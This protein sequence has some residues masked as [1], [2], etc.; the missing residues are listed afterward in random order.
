MR[1]SATRGAAGAFGSIGSDVDPHHAKDISFGG[2]VLDPHPRF[3]ELLAT[4]PVHPGS[5]S[6]QFATTS[7]DAML[8]PEDQQYTAY[9]FETVEA[10]FRDPNTFSSA[11]MA[12]LFEDVIGRTILEM[13]PPEHQRYRTLIQPGFTKAEMDRWEAEFVRDVVNGHIDRFVDDGR[14]DL[15]TDF[16]LHYPIHVTAVAIGLPTDDLSHFYREAVT[17]TNPFISET[18]RKRASAVLGDVLQRLIDERRRTR[19]DDLVST[20]V[21][22]SFRD[23]S[24]A[25]AQELTDEAIVAFARQL[26]PA[27]AQTTSDMITTLLFA[28]LTHPEQLAAVTDQPSLIPQAVEEGLRWESSITT[29]GRFT[30]RDVV[31]EDVPVPAASLVNLVV[32]AAN[33][34]PSRWD[35][36]HEF[37][38]FRDQRPHIAFAHGPHICLGIHAARMELRVA[39]ELLLER[40]PNLRLDPEAPD[41]HVH[42]LTFRRADH[43]PVIWG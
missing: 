18:E 31:L 27:G 38:I 23:P 22:A 8:F 43:L 20:L 19:A 24:E 35:R 5:V 13:D 14:A 33:R 36:P 41:V 39:L 40:L 17:I 30:T 6:A 3:A 32:A 11:W 29:F 10:V 26:I 21:D 1:H 16:A 7:V 28:L 34:D 12:P 15:S 25:T 37:D 2:E 9:R 42:G 4:S